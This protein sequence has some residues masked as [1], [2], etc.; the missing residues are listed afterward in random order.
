[1]QLLRE[2]KGAVMMMTAFMIVV[3][4]FVSAIVL[5][6][7]RVWV[8]KARLQT[9]VDAAALAAIRGAKVSPIISY[10]SVYETRT[11]VIGNTT[12]TYRVEVGKKEIVKGYEIELPGY[13][14][15]F[16]ADRVVYRNAEDWKE[17]DY[18]GSPIMPKVE[19]ASVTMSPDGRSATVRV[20]A[21]TGVPSLLY[22]P[23]AAGVTGNEDR[24]YITVHVVSES[25]VKLWN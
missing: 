7:G 8:V 19:F 5:D 4:L 18:D 15:R 12:E 24:R 16:E 25:S 10:E 21:S 11:R 6:L 22:G 9:A 17:K 1:M 13:Q 23:L 14:A 3:A 20:M 2:E